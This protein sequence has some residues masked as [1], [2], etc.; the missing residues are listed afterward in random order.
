MDSLKQVYNLV[1]DYP[2]CSQAKQTKIVFVFRKMCVSSPPW[3]YKA[4]GGGGENMGFGVKRWMMLEHRTHDFAVNFGLG[5]KNKRA[6]DYFYERFVGSW[7]QE[8]LLWGMG[9]SL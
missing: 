8:D 7:T 9:N 2:T 3:I 1:S 6:K 5:E 4:V